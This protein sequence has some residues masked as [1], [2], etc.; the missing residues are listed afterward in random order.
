M[1]FKVSKV[2][3]RTGRKRII[4]STLSLWSRIMTDSVHIK[5]TEWLW[6]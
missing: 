5:R 2:S 1:E 3:L 4:L 6:P